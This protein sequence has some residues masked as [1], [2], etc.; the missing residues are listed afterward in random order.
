MQ[1]IA[2]DTAVV[3]RTARLA[4]FRAAAADFRVDAI[5]DP[6]DF[7]V[8]WR[9][10]TLGDIN[11]IHCHCSPVRYRREIETIAADGEDRVTIHCYMK[12]GEVGE[13]AGRPVEVGPGGATVW[14]L[15]APVDVSS[16]EPLEAL[17]VTLP[18]YLVDEV[19][20]SASVA[21]ALAPSAELA[22]AVAQGRHMIDGA[23]ELPD[24]AG[25]FLGRA[26]RDMFAVAMLPTHAATHA[27]RPDPPLLQRMTDL[28]DAHLPGELDLEALAAALEVE[29]ERVARVADHFGGLPLLAERRRLLRAYRLLCDPRETDTVLEIAQRCGFGSLPRFS[30]RFHSVFHTSARD[31]RRF[32]HGHG[33]LPGWAGAYHVEQLYGAMIS[34]PAPRLRRA[35]GG[36]GRR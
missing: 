29:I 3:P 17:I 25:M 10:L 13:I 9:M 22:L 26:L 24:D 20:P 1:V 33:R 4:T 32:G 19:L 11:L 30:R 28:I 35:P 15:T 34:S 7:A 27:A 6:D 14:D 2:F 8:R 12:G 18:R 5:G 36:G 23:D 21:G 31:L 16:S